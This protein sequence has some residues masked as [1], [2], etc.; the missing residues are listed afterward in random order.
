LKSRK[1]SVILV[2][3]LALD[4]SLALGAGFILL[5]QYG[6]GTTYP[7]HIYSTC[8]SISIVYD[9]KSATF[10]N[11]IPAQGTVHVTPHSNITVY[12]NLNQGCSVIGW[13]TSG[14]GD[15]ATTYP[16]SIAMGDIMS[17]TTVIAIAASMSASAVP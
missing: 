2:L 17:A 14:G 12:A 4:I 1:P 10:S 11:G 3:V 9:G 6:G 16:D 13:S 5:S 8:G 15:S 7:V